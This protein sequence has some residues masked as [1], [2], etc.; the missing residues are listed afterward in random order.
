VSIA[1]QYW[2][3]MSRTLIRACGIVADPPGLGAA[4][5]SRLRWIEQS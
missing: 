3:E 4:S 1:R 2:L 5:A